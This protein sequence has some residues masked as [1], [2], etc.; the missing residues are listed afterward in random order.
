MCRLGGQYISVENA[1]ISSSHVKGESIED[2]IRTVSQYA[3]AIVIRH[4]DE[5]AVEKGASAAEVP[6]INAGD[7]AGEHPTQALIDLYTIWM[8][9]HTF[10]N[11][12]VVVLGSGRARTIHSLLILMDKFPSIKVKHIVDLGKEQTE[13]VCECDVL[14]MTRIQHER[15]KAG[16][17]KP[18][19]VTLQ[20]EVLNCMKEKAM[21]LHP[22]PR[23]EELPIEVDNDPR[24]AYWQQVKNGLFLRMALLESIFSGDYSRQYK[25]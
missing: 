21:I 4:P 9:R 5:G 20:K 12:S 15:F 14:Y 1:K 16:E 11:L 23:Q 3:D 7:G 8:R 2:T 24:A 10:E 17:Q 19:P 6:V 25:D 13:Q 22:L 18:L